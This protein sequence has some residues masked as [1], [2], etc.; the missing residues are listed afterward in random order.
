VLLTAQWR[1]AIQITSAAPRTNYKHPFQP[2]DLGLMLKQ[3]RLG[4]RVGEFSRLF[5]KT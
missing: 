3:L 4:L 1:G 2:S 5:F